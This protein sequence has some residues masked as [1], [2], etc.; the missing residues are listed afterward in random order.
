ML[1]NSYVIIHDFLFH[2]GDT[3]AIN[4]NAEG[5]NNSWDIRTFAHYVH[6]AVVASYV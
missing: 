2:Q 3:E 6:I 1:S 5:A 4:S